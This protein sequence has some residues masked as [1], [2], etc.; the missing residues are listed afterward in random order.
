[1]LIPAMEKK[2]EGRTFV[3]LDIRMDKV[4]FHGKATFEHKRPENG[5]RNKD[6]RKERMNAR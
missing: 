5:S 6:R 3:V 4:N 2:T 1:M